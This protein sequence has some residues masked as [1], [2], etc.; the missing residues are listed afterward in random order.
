M[1]LAI[2]VV[3]VTG[4]ALATAVITPA[5]PPSGGGGR[6]F[7][8]SVSGPAPLRA[9]GPAPL[10]ATGSLIGNPYSAAGQRGGGNR[11]GYTRGGFVNGRG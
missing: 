5:G 2:R 6:G 9:S 10:H 4:L 11:G 7:S 3:L 1:G 8:G